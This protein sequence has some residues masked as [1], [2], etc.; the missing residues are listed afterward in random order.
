MICIIQCSLLIGWE[1]SHS[2]KMLV[3]ATNVQGKV[4]LK[5]LSD[6]NVCEF[7]CKFLSLSFI[8]PL[9][10]EVIL[11]TLPHKASIILTSCNCL[12]LGNEFNHSWT[13]SLMSTVIS[14][15]SKWKF[16]DGRRHCEFLINSPI[17]LMTHCIFLFMQKRR[18]SLSQFSTHE[19]L[20]HGCWYNDIQS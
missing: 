17:V 6:L 20:F 11:G 8:K 16:C 12:C 14:S 15:Q 1:I 2:F 5:Q 13:S 19:N 9:M 3:G 18:N 10:S 7:L 4:M